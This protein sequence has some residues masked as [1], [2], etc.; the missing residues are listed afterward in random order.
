[1]VVGDAF[2]LRLVGQKVD[3]A[4]EATCAEKRR[5]AGRGERGVGEG[6]CVGACGCTL[7]AVPLC[8]R[9]LVRMRV[10]MHMAALAAAALAALAALAAAALTV[11][12]V[13]GVGYLRLGAELGHED[14]H[15][16][17]REGAHSKDGMHRLGDCVGA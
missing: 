8:V 2:C 13:V 12:K 6:G 9:A 7:V 16:L 5:R 17:H 11:A 14:F 4:E 15:G 10:P 3:D 1:M